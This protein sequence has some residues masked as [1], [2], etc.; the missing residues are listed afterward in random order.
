[1]QENYLAVTI[2][3]YI[4]LVKILGMRLLHAEVSLLPYLRDR[5]QREYGLTE[6]ELSTLYSTGLLIA[7][8]QQ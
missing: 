1:M 7:K 5:W 2:E 3:D 6:E 4:A 8:K